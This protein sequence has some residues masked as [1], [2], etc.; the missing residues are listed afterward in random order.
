MNSRRGGPPPSAADPHNIAVG[1]KF[2]E[3]RLRSYKHDTE[4]HHV[5]MFPD[6]NSFSVNELVQPVK[7]YRRRK[8]WDATSNSDRNKGSEEINMEDSVGGFVKKKKKTL[9]LREWISTEERQARQ[10]EERP[11]IFEDSDG[12]GWN[13]R[14]EGGMSSRK[15]SS[16]KSKYVL[17]VNQ[18]SEFRVLPVQKWY[19]FTQKIN[20]QTLPL[21]EAELKVC[22]LVLIIS[23][24]F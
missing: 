21:E 19:R 3:F 6:R 24:N 1:T 7:L 16:G 9:V 17:F 11:W 12:R 4:E 10:L 18:G 13:G 15:T 2:N 20:Y 5:M 14:L 8:S 22:Y 23:T